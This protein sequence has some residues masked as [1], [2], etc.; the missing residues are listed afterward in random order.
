[1]RS[2]NHTAEKAL[3][4]GL[5]CAFQ[6]GWLAVSAAGATPQQGEVP[7]KSLPVLTRVEEI[8][9]LT[10]E[11]AQRGYPVHLRGV[12]TFN[13]PEFG[14]TFFH[15]STF[16]IFLYT[17]GAPSEARAGDLVEVR[18]VTGPGD[19]APV[20]DRP[21]I[22]VLGRTA[23]PP[24]RRFRL[25]DLLT[26]EE[27]SQWVEVG[28]VVHSAG[29][30]TRLPPDMREGPPFLVLSIVAGRNKF[31]ARIGEF[32]RATNY[33]Y[34]VD[35]VVKVR[36][37]CGTLFNDKRQ[38]VGIQLFVPN[39]DQVRIEE[40]APSDAYTL[41]I[42]P[43]RS[44]MLFTPEKAS[45]HRVRVRGIV[46]LQRLGRSLFI[47]DGTG[48]LYVQSRQPTQLYPGDT[49]EAVGFPAVGEYAPFLEDAIFRKLASGP[50]LVPRSVTAQEAAKGG[51]GAGLVRVD[52][53][54][55]EGALR[56]EEQV[57]ILQS[58]DVIFNAL[59]EDAKAI[60]RLRAL[61]AGSRL[62][63]T[64]VCSVQVDENRVPRAFRILLR[65]LD[66]V[67][68]LE[69]PPWLTRQHALAILGIAGALFLC[70]LVWVGLLRGRVRE[71]TATIRE[72]LRREAALKTQYMNLFENARDVVYTADLNGTITSMNKAGEQ[73]SGYARTEVVGKNFSQLIPQKYAAR[74]RTMLEHT[75]AGEE[76]AVMEWEI[77]AKDGHRVPL[78]VSARLIRQDGRPVGVQG[79]ARD[80]T[81]RKR[82]EA[83]LIA[84]RHLLHTLMD[85]LP[86]YIY[87][88]DSES[89]FIRTNKAHA[90]A[91]GLDDPAQ[92]IGKTDFD[93]FTDEHAQLAYA[94]EQQ[95]IRTGQPMLAKEEKETWPDGR[96]T[97]V[98][99]T[100]MPLRDANGNIVGTF[101]I[102][103]DITERKRAEEALQVSEG[104]LAQ[105]MD[106]A[107]L[108]HWERDP[109]SG[110]FI[111][112][113][114]FYA[115]YGTTAER[116]GGYQ[117]SP[118]TYFREFLPPEDARLVADEVAKAAAMTDQNPSWALE[119]RIRR[120]DGEIR[121]FL[122][123][124]SVIKN[125][126][127]LTIKTRGVNQDITERKKA[128]ESLRASEQRYRLLFERNLAGVYRSTL[129]GT[130][131]E[132]NE[133]CCRIFGC[134]SPQELMA[135][136]ARDLYIHPG[137]RENFLRR[138]R[139][140]RTLT[141]LEMC[142]RK[143]DGHPVWVLENATLLDSQDGAPP[144]LEGT[145]VDITERKWAEAELQLAKEDA[146]AASRAKSE[147]LAIMSH[148]IRTPMN[149][150]IGMT[151][152]ALDTELTPEQREYLST[153]KE[154]ADALLTLINDILDFSRIEAGKLDLDVTE[155]NLHDTLGN[156]LKVLAL[157]AHQK[158]L[159]L[160]C[161]IPP[162]MSV[163]L[164]GDPGRLRQ[165]I[166]NLVGNAVKFTERG[167]VV[168]SVEVESEAAEEIWLHFAVADT[169]VGIPPDQ[170]RRIFEAFAQ[171]DSSTTRRYG[172]SGLGLAISSRLVEMM[173]G[174]MWLES[175]L[176]KGSTFHFTARF[177]VQK[178][179]LARPARREVADLRGLPVL[180]VDDNATN[181]RILDA[182]LRH[183]LMKPGLADG[184]RAGL[185]A[186]EQ[187]KASG[188]AFPLVLLD[189]QM[190]DMDG[191][192]LAERIRRDPALVGATIMMLTSAGQ[193]GDAARCRELGIAAY[194]IKPIRQSELLE[195]ILIALGKQAWP[196]GR[197]ELITRHSLREA[198]RKLRVLLA[199]DNVV[200]QKLV[201]RLLEKRG[202][203]VQVA[204][205][206]R[207]VLEMLDVA[208]PEEFDVVLM[209]VQMPEMDGLQA[210][211]AIRERE[212]T[213]GKHL[214][215]VA[216]T[217]HA[218]KADR[219]RCLAAGMDGYISKPLKS[220]ELLEAIEGLMR[221]APQEEGSAGEE[222]R[223]GQ[224]MDRAAALAGVGGDTRLLEELAGLFLD[225]CAKL[226]SAVQ[227]A[228]ARLNPRQLE[229][230]AHSL[231]SSV[232]NFA[233]QPAFEMA[234]R[235]EMMGRQGDLTG[236]AEAYAALDGEIKRL[237]SALVALGEEARA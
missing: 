116:E 220:G 121:Y 53:R 72:Q 67:V 152:L 231:K 216:M 13:L 137:D 192:T 225:D 60:P 204:V 157:R 167:E 132:A 212:K 143:A 1:M 35:G 165:V 97:W 83:A 188:Q 63:L 163:A 107:R 214:P 215:I 24:A 155:F 173:G 139:E 178:Q 111:F 200:N 198:R 79:I 223:P 236:A 29:F 128:E 187:A 65:S 136:Q 149:G 127:G 14:V 43:S 177:G 94:D 154:S 141:N 145:L 162:D 30:E 232:G 196:T 124:S 185:A 224:V 147:F 117:M 228:V 12:I 144:V 194:L 108:A 164:V 54:L 161:R 76:P 27:D 226:L 205:N 210:T 134:A 52:G 208:A 81:E 22:R 118:E 18:G 100:K 7:K 16:G 57:L 4:T 40:R 201:V 172:G 92:V 47:Q 222:L 207:E 126:E 21:Q 218:L 37:A 56:P 174:R 77:V 217:A 3:L 11:E 135:H 202:H 88:K 180:V 34:L 175:E 176:G 211:A 125:S 78:E 5:L 68:V 23:L 206:G 26:G 2:R 130:I 168:L 122:V 158:G 51:F 36:G 86:D 109:A 75:V 160:A 119:H 17:L 114:R 171:A 44:L 10:T 33:D 169:G 82:A 49:V 46:T 93:F 170:Q 112:N 38:L 105:A 45:G 129:D 209:D 9:N 123:R 219:E 103:R 197:P 235:L 28:G 8:R 199:E 234:A 90:K 102:S 191:F 85:N 233:A 150:I 41:P 25:E 159:E 71:Q 61:P 32:Q 146:E 50:P 66:D 59:L 213:S 230:A 48:S 80:I 221:E 89:R 113:D 19:F 91:F 151:E 203:T 195:A 31:K 142:L 182:M 166:A 148:E 181:R 95:I 74:A 153:V 193:R 73:V 133:A 101:G 99:T 84:E 189:A 156:T 70:A 15:D 55:L 190:P 138:L 64:G 62:R 87:F 227:E 58:G 115:L 237:Q 140:E 184:G 110:M 69:R 106:M 42:V 39:L 131:L 120:R 98:A 183:W 179:P 6:M 229:R 20:V 186:L 104:Q 96:E